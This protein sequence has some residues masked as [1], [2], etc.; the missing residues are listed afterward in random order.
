MESNE[1]R[2][3]VLQV[4]APHLPQL[5]IEPS[6]SQVAAELVK[7][8]IA[9]HNPPLATMRQGSAKCLV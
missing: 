2:A 5:W 8:S 7:G 4:V 3:A 6:T 1:L 9:T